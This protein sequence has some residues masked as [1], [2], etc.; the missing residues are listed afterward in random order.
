LAAAANAQSGG[1]ASQTDQRQAASGRSLTIARIGEIGLP[2]VSP[3]LACGGELSFLRAI[4]AD[5]T[6]ALLPRASPLRLTELRHDQTSNAPASL[7]QKD[8]EGIRKHQAADSYKLVDKLDLSCVGELEGDVLRREIRLR[9]RALCDTED[10]YQSQ[11]ERDRLIE[12]VLD[13]T[14][15][16]GPLGFWLMELDQRNHDQ[17]PEKRLHRAERPA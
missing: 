1:V 16:P 8:K 12:E 13:E 7:S 6:P 5:G 9:G 14:F 11:R 3:P 17:R 4:P 15:G 2:S 10:T